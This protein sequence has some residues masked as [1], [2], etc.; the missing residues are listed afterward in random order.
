MN[1]EDISILM[2]FLNKDVD[3]QVCGIETVDLPLLRALLSL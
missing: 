3:L 2:Y 1:S